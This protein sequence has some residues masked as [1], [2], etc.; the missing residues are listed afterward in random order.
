MNMKSRYLITATLAIYLSS[1]RFTLCIKGKPDRDYETLQEAEKVIE[2]E[3]GAFENIN[4]YL[5]RGKHV[6]RS[7]VCARGNAMVIID[8]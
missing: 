5:Q 7:Y 8:K 1:M 2:K 6:R 4:D 3:L